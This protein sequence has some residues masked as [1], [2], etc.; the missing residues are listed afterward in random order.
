MYDCST[1]TCS[2]VISTTYQYDQTGLKSTNGTTPQQGT[3]TGSRGNL[4]TLT[5]SPAN[6]Y[7]PLTKTFSYYDTGNLYVATD[8]NGAQT[9]YTYG[10]CGNSF[11]TAV[12]EPLS[13][14]RSMSWNC[15]GGVLTQANDENGNATKADYSSDANYW[16]P[17]NTTDEANYVTNLQYTT[18]SVE[19]ALQNFNNGASAWDFLTTVDGFG[20]VIYN[21]QLQALGGSNYD[22]VETDYNTLGQA[23]RNTMPYSATASPGTNN[24]TVAGK[25]VS[26]DALGRVVGVTQGT[27]SSISYQATYQYIQNDVLVTVGKSGG[28]QF[29]RQ[30]EYDGLGRLT[31]VCEITTAQNV[32]AGPCAPQSNSEIGFLTTY[33][34]NVFGE[35]TSVTQNTQANALYGSQTRTYSYD[36]LGRLTKEQN[37]ESWITVYTWDHTPQAVCGGY[38]SEP[39]DLMVKTN[40]DNSQICFVYDSLHRVTTQGGTVCRRF[41]YDNTSNKLFTPPTGYPAQNLEGRLVEAET[42]NCTAWPPTTGTK[43]TDEWFNWG[44]RGDILDEYQSTPNST[45]YYHTNAGYGRNY[46]LSSLT[47]YNNS[48]TRIT[49]VM[50]YGVDS[51]GRVNGVTSGS[52]SAVTGV[53]FSAGDSTGPL[54]AITKVQLGSGDSDSFKYDPNT[55]TMT[56][57]SATIGTTPQTM[58]GSLSWGT[59]G[60][61]QS[62]TIVDPFNS[63]DNQTCNYTY[64][65]LSRI[66][67]DSCNNQTQPWNQTFSYDAFG[68]ITKTGNDTWTPTYSNTINQYL[69]G[70]TGGGQN[71]VSYDGNGRL[72]NDTFNTYTWDTWGD[73]TSA[74]AFPATYDAFGRMVES[75]TGSSMQQ[76]IYSPAGGP[77]LATAHAQ[78]LNGVYLPLPGGAIAMIGGTGPGQYNHPDWLGSARVFSSPSQ[79][80]T[81]GFAYAPFGEGYAETSNQW[82]QFT[83]FGDAWTVGG[84][85]NQGGTLDDFMYRRYSPG[86]GRWI[87]PDP[88]GLAAVDPTNPQTW[89]RYAY[90]GNNPLSRTD[91]LG[92]FYCA[93]EFDDGGGGGGGVTDPSGGDPCFLYGMDC[94]GQG[95]SEPPIDPGGGGGRGGQL[96]QAQRSASNALNDPTCAQAVDGGTGAAS[97]TIAGT[98]GASMGSI[99]PGS[100][101]TGGRLSGQ[102]NPGIPDFGNLYPFQMNVTLNTDRPGFFTTYFTNGGYQWGEVDGYGPIATQTIMLLHETGHQAFNN[103]FFTVVL[104]D[105]GVYGAETSL[106]NSANVGAACV[107]RGDFGGN[108]GPLNNGTGVVPAIVRPV[109]PVN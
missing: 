83:E 80:A 98:Q 95:P 6:V 67:G 71:A 2:Q 13:L 24:T 92:L 51:E 90:V 34:Y 62:L 94:G 65:D 36:G 100:L 102:A 55:G 42:D 46:A 89:N 4:T 32:G 12:A 66:A 23:S 63:Y 33:T 28:Q 1:G 29:Q 104:P 109:R 48:G 54:G 17:D 56:Y 59:N 79:G 106:E 16:R 107:P 108:Q 9:T 70:W 50:G 86:Q 72:L 68:N 27:S 39:G 38:T 75:G 14:S 61:L 43:I 69:T 49:P 101:G 99:Q 26:Y 7:A 5:V 96:Q 57:Y 87:S 74:N 18:N 81:K 8:V 105:G 15:T 10:D 40:G 64:D 91:P 3:I 82:I 19:S 60:T 35:I 20:R 97:S 21:Q 84:N 30:L 85:N 58:S 78:I 103:G 73:L 76:Y 93:C 88:A 25:S 77:P 11:L 37:P 45:G 47:L 53:T 31:S 41:R 22:T 52:V 44:L